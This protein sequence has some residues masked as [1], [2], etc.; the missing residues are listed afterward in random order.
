MTVMVMNTCG[1]RNTLKRYTS[2]GIR[3]L[4][5][6]GV[7]LCKRQTRIN[8]S[9]ILCDDRAS[10]DGAETDKVSGHQSSSTIG[11][12]AHLPNSAA[13]TSMHAS[14]FTFQTHILHNIMIRALHFLAL[15]RHDRCTTQRK[16]PAHV[17][18]AETNERCTICTSRPLHTRY[19]PPSS[20]SHV[21][22]FLHL[23]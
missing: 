11:I 9:S 5:N 14:V 22:V 20:H 2:V 13:H 21:Q 15:G 16:T 12:V 8:C 17:G 4:C 19:T 23:V 10:R 3:L 7:V 1:S 18:R 6:I